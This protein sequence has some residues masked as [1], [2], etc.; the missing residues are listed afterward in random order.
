MLGV[1]IVSE[2]DGLIWQIFHGE[3]ILMLRK[4]DMGEISQ[5]WLTIC[6]FQQSCVD[7]FFSSLLD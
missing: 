4:G 7:V 2:N 1:I 6:S 5:F 3:L